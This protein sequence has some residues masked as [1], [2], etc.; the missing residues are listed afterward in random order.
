VALAGAAAAIRL[1]IGSPARQD[2][3]GRVEETLAL[4]RGRMT[5]D[6]YAD[7]WRAGRTATVEDLLAPG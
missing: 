4:A 7:A 3:R 1:K 6:D 2:E 5:P